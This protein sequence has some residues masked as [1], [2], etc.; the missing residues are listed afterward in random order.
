MKSTHCVLALFLVACGT[1]VPKV[2]AIEDASSSIPKAENILR[3]PITHGDTPIWYYNESENLIIE[4][5]AETLPQD[6]IFLNEVSIANYPKTPEK[7]PSSFILKRRDDQI[8]ILNYRNLEDSVWVQYSQGKLTSLEFNNYS[9][10]DF[11]LEDLPVFQATLDDYKERYPGSY[12]LR[13][14]FPSYLLQDYHNLD[15]VKTIDLTFLWTEGAR[16]DIIW[17]NKYAVHAEF[18]FF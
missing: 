4:E 3:S 11:R 14:L 7:L 8:D 13:N 18:R 1:K 6:Q 2:P 15:S 9:N 5:I 16:I 17:L 12:S 10:T